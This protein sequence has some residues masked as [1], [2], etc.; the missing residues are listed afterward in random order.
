[1]KLTLQKFLILLEIFI[2]LSNVYCQTDIIWEC[3]FENISDLDSFQLDLDESTGV[4]CDSF[5]VDSQDFDMEIVDYQYGQSSKALELTVNKKAEGGKKMGVIL[6]RNIEDFKEGYIYIFEGMFRKSPSIG[7]ESSVEHIDVNISLVQDSVEYFA[8]IF[9]TL[10]KWDKKYGWIWTRD[11]LCD[12]NNNLCIDADGVIK[13]DSMPEDTNWHVF[14]IQTVYDLEIRRIKS[15]AIDRKIIELNIDMGVNHIKKPWSS[16]F[17]VLCEMQ[18]TNTNCDSTLTFVGK[19]QWDN[20]KVMKQKVNMND[21]PSYL[22]NENW[23]KT[24]YWS[25]YKDNDCEIK[26]SPYSGINDDGLKVEYNLKPNSQES[27]WVIMRTDSITGYNNNKPIVMFLKASGEVDIEFK[28]IDNDGSVFGKRASLEKIYTDWT[29][30]ALFQNDLDYWW[31]GDEIFNELA[32]FEI[33]FSG[34]GRGIVGIDEIGIGKEDQLSGLYLD[35]YRED[36]TIGFNQCRDSILTP[37][38]TLVLEYLKLIQD[39]SSSDAKLLQTMEDGVVSTFNNSLVAITFILKNEKERAERILDFYSNATD[40]NN[41]DIRLQNFFYNGEARGFYQN[42]SLSDY[43]AGYTDP[44]WIG[45][46][47]WLLVAYKYYEIKY[48]SGKYHYITS[49]LKDLLLSF[50]IEEGEGGYIRHGWRNGDSYLHESIGHHEGNIDCYAALKLCGEDSIANRIKIWLDYE[51]DSLKNNKDLPL[52]LYT[53]RVLAYGEGYEGLLDILETDLRF[54]KTL[55]INEKKVKG[56]YP[57]P[58]LD[59]NNIWIDGLGHISCA[60]LVYGDQGKGNFYAN[61]FD[62]L[63][64]EYDLFGK[65]IKTFPYSVNKSGEFGWVDTTKG[66]I[67][68]AAWYI[69]AK[70]KFNPLIIENNVTEVSEEICH[71]DSIFFNDQ[72]LKESGFY[73]D[74]LI[75]TEGKDSII[76]LN[77]KIYPVFEITENISICEGESYKGNTESGTYYTNLSTIYGCDSIIVTNLNVVDHDSCYDNLSDYL[78]IPDIRIFPNPSNGKFN[79]SIQD[80]NKIYFI[81]VINLQGQVIYSEKNVIFDTNKLT[82]INLS[83]FPKGMYY[84]KFI[85]VYCVTVQPILVGY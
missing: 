34:K 52:D 81:N 49:L 26:L 78:N 51:L 65:T 6:H 33:A 27:G 66:F 43:H 70:N 21:F 32:G 22:E 72:Y 56:F 63:F 62:K 64:L 17:K 16:H 77:L 15:I 46:M 1:M 9:W 30:V 2:F 3:D 38:D 19:S 35:P 44:R 13:L 20:L 74:T 54:K 36:P 41:T 50:Y 79:I 8:E 25:F 18:N 11:T 53:W 55:E 76:K 48:S 47:A 39:S 75:T 80:I 82:E 24:L 84:L 10:N 40:S 67:S 37:E 12:V 58:T 31:G 57:F 68:C 29:S 73:F 14:Q 28:F 5:P 45:D 71:D 69:L 61:Q 23:D 7:L 83:G 42:I 59:F 60:Y 4:M 85:S